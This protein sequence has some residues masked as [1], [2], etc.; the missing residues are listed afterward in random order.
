LAGEFKLMMGRGPR[1]FIAWKERPRSEGGMAAKATTAANRR[2]K[3]SNPNLRA[4]RAMFDGREC[5]VEACT[6]FEARTIAMARL[7]CGQDRIVVRAI[8][9]TA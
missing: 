8:D 5:Q 3:Q 9:A 2:V 6:W 1:V 4:W 7:G